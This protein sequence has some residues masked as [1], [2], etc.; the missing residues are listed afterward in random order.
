MSRKVLVIA[1]VLLAA[2][3][4][5]AVSAPLF[6]GGHMRHGAL[7]GDFAEGGYGLAAHPV[8]LGE[9]LKAMDADKDGTITLE[10]FLARRD[11]AFARFDKNKDGV[12]D[13]AEF[14]A[15]AKESTDYWTRRFLK[16]FDADKDGKVSKE[17]F[18]RFARERFAWRD[19]DDDGRIGLEDMPPGVR[20]RIGRWLRRGQDDA[21]K[22]AKDGAAAKEAQERRPF[23]LE[24]LLGRVDRRFTRLDRNGDGF[25][26]AA[27]LEASVAERNAY[28]ARRFFKRFDA[29]GDG[30]VTRAEFDRRAGQRFADL[31]LDGDGK[32]TEADLPPM[33]RG[34]GLLR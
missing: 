32:I 10:E 7:F 27:D 33:M 20:D 21:G 1:G 6:R 3:S 11:P 23:T 30:K 26:D 13:R 28:A 24:R 5:A 17:E 8:R 4:I 9:R 34:R 15:A 29:D 18:A 19:L 25:I 22:D 16:R 31:D 12:I 2:G 14:D